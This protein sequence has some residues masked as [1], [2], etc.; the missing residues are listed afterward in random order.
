MQFNIMNYLINSYAVVHSIFMNCISD[1]LFVNCLTL[2]VQWKASVC[3]DGDQS[4]YH[5]VYHHGVQ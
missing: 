1:K 3:I 2:G 4:V 5:G